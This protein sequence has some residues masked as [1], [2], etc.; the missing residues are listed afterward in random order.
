MARRAVM[1]SGAEYARST[2]SPGSPSYSIAH[3]VEGEI[4]ARRIRWCVKNVNVILFF[5]VALPF[6]GVS[7]LSPRPI[8]SPKGTNSIAGA[9]PPV[10]IEDY[11]P[12][13]GLH[14][15]GVM[16]PLQGWSN[17]CWHPGAMPPAIEFVPFGEK[18]YRRSHLTHPRE[19]RLNRSHQRF[20]RP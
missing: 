10:E 7:K 12:C 20:K 2:T 5:S 13:K 3:R 11:Q 9:P 14:I 8:S 1:P 17:G 6:R 19:R 18:R 4:E 15:I 16:Q